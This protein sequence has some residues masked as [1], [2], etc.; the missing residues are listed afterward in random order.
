MLKPTSRSPILFAGIGNE[1]RGDDAIGLIIAQK[2]Q[3]ERIDHVE[4]VVEDGEILSLIDD[5][6]DRD[7][8]FL[9][10]AVSSGSDPGKFFQL[11]ALTHKLPKEYFQFSSHSIGV[12]EIVNLG[13]KLNQIPEHLIIFG[14]E[15]QN[16]EIG[17]H[18]T[19]AV[20]ETLTEVY[21]RIVKKVKDTAKF[22][23]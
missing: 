20:S 10:D 23:N 1:F 3:R 8:V 5:W 16:F 12:P 22:Y 21:P 9:C 4:I 11:D 13:K 15:G 17:Q 14:I 19:K 2:L 7:Y 18:I 6:S